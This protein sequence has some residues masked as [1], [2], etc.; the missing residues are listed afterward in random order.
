V[1]G[2]TDAQ[3][4]EGLRKLEVGHFDAARP[5]P[6]QQAANLITARRRRRLEASGQPFVDRRP[7][8]GSPLFGRRLSAAETL[9]RC[10]QYRVEQRVKGESEGIGQKHLQAS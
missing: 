1:A 9:R 10:R 4:G 7:E 8:S 5:D 6:D 2:N 3:S